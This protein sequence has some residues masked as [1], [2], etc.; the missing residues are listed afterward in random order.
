[1]PD[2]TRTSGNYNFCIFRQILVQLLS[3]D[4]QGSSNGNLFKQD[5]ILFYLYSYI[6]LRLVHFWKI[7][8]NLYIFSDINN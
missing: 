8:L 1:M 7:Y 4:C 2:E 6:Y 3:L 5:L